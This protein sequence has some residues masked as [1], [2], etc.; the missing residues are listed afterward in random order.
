MPKVMKED[1]Q[2]IKA[3][4]P[5]AMMGIDLFGPL[6][7]TADRNTYI[8]T[9]T[10]FFTKLTEAFPIPSKN[11]KE[12]GKCIMK[13]FFHHGA[14][15]AFLLDNGGEFV[16][17]ISKLLPS[18]G[19]IHAHMDRFQAANVKLYEK[20]CSNVA[21]AQSK[22]KEADRKKILSKQPDLKVGSKVLVSNIGIKSQ[23]G[24]KLEQ[25]YSSPVRIS[26]IQGNRF[27]LVDMEGNVLKKP[28][29]KTRLKLYKEQKGNGAFPSPIGARIVKDED[30]RCKNKFCLLILHKTAGKFR[31][32]KLVINAKSDERRSAANQ[33]RTADGNTYILTATDFFTKLTEAFP[34]P[35]KNAKE[36]AKCIMKLFSTTVLAMLFCWITEVNL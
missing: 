4:Y 10:D 12:V 7:R 14:C 31:G 8:F 23:K 32:L 5:F 34:I 19:D 18:K 17:E 28:V 26:E 30:V 6:K 25:R 36:V 33:K 35:S 13:L 29:H 21:V 9:A 1:L 11:A 27:F 3:K 22:Q 16:N 24:R 20:L 2:P 15:H